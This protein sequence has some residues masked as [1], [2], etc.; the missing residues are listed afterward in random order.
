MQAVTHGKCN[1]AAGCVQKVAAVAL[2][3]YQPVGG[4][5]VRAGC[6]CI[7]SAGRSSCSPELAMAAQTGRCFAVGW[8][9]SHTGRP[10]SACLLGTLMCLQELCKR[11][12]DPFSDIAEVL[13]RLEDCSS[14]KCCANSSRKCCANTFQML[15]RT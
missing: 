12:S 11:F 10:W 4:K 8:E 9:S 13:Q 2:A 6:P 7:C 3:A 5:Q 14:R 1:R 15:P